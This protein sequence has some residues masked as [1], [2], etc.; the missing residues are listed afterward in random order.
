MP[1][2]IPANPPS[3]PP[4]PPLPPPR[5]PSSAEPSPAK[6]YLARI[7]RLAVEKPQIRSPHHGKRPDLKRQKRFDLPLRKHIFIPK[8]KPPKVPQELC[9]AYFTDGNKPSLVVQR[10]V[11]HRTGIPISS[12]DASP[13]RTRAVVAGRDILKIIH[14]TKDGCIEEHNLRAAIIAY[15][16]THESAKGTTSAGHK[17]NLAANDVKWSHGSFSKKIAI[18]AANGQIVVYDVEK[19]GLDWARLHEHNRQVHTLGFNPYEGALMLSGSQ[20]ATVRLW[21]LRDH[22]GDRG[23]MAMQSKTRFSGNSDVVRDLRWSPTNVFEFAI[24]TDGGMI[25]RW[26]IR[27]DS[28]PLLR[29]RAHEKTCNAVDWH[30][31]G[32]HLVSAGADKEVKVWDFASSDRRMKPLWSLRAPQAVMRA[33][34]RPASWHAGKSNGDGSWQSTQVAT[35]LDREDPRILIWD[36]RRPYV[37]TRTF[38]R[39]DLPPSALYWHSD[40]LLWSVGAHGIFTQTDIVTL[41]LRS[42]QRVPTIATFTPRSTIFQISAPASQRPSQQRPAQAMG[43]SKSSQSLRGRKGSADS[44]PNLGEQPKKTDRTSKAMRP[45]PPASEPSVPVRPL[46]TSLSRGP[47][48]YSPSQRLAVVKIP[49]IENRIKVFRFYAENYRMLPE[50]TKLRESPNLLAVF[51]EMLRYNCKVAQ[52]VNQKD[53]AMAWYTLSQA[54]LRELK[55]RADENRERRLQAAA[56]ESRKPTPNPT[57]LLSFQPSA[58]F[59]Q[60]L[61]PHL[62]IFLKGGLDSLSILLLT[63]D[64]NPAIDYSELE[65]FLEPSVVE[66]ED[67]PTIA[68][69]EPDKPAETEH[70]VRILLFDMLILIYGAFFKCFR[71]VLLCCP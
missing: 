51:S 44:S 23:V 29:T 64:K 70:P 69:I 35:S 38:N 56:I 18:A 54:I 8:L 48:V 13:D 20:D 47:S 12:L 65:A 15:A 55:Q 32:R 50:I 34:W 59:T 7:A 42:R 31:D 9:Q 66:S 67:Q 25:Q 17:D 5:T 41:P 62:R 52:R 27:K 37:P 24:G 10:N 22:A 33:R 16:S 61:P 11:T 36:Y 19:A 26:D 53:V 3:P 14:V 6:D 57:P 2:S 30:P 39:Y 40:E 68:R 4:A 58:A 28:A 45:L 63:K 21:D 71:Y 46:D 49:S 1:E 60:S 43:N